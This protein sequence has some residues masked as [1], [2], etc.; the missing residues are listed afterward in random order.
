[1]DRN[2]FTNEKLLIVI[3]DRNKLLFQGEIKAVSSFNDKGPFDILP[4]HANFISIIKKH[5]VI[6]LRTKEKKRIELESGIL[7][8]RDNNVEV[9][10]G[11]LK[12]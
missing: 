6:H 8:V 11:I 2:L 7:K 12:K 3:R 5:L 1:M 9:Y 4:Q 10:L